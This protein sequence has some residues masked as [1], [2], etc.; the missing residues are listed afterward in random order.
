MKTPTLLREMNKDQR[1]KKDKE[2]N[3][4]HIKKKNT[5]ILLNRP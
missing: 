2:S 3:I 5:K 4:G 1:R